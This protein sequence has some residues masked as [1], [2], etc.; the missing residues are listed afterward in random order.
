MVSIVAAILVLATCALVTVLTMLA[1]ARGTWS[2]RRDP[3]LAGL[4]LAAL[5]L[6]A[7]VAAWR[8]VGWGLT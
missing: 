4:V 3:R 6:T 5:A 7:Q 1:W 8:L 2:P